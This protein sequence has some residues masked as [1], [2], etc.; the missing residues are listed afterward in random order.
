MQFTI[1][2]GIMAMITIKII[3]NAII[4]LIITMLTMK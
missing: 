1:M 2:I 4:S 3:N